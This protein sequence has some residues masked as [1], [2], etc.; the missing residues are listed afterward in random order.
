MFV[1]DSI[2]SFFKLLNVALLLLVSSSR[3]YL[4]HLS[5][6]RLHMQLSFTLI[7]LSLQIIHIVVYIEVNVD[8]PWLSR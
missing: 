3:F 6:T 4:P 1:K 2:F 5:I 7:H 8:V